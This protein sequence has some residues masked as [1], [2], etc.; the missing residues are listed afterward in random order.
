MRFDIDG[1]ILDTGDLGLDTANDEVA[2]RAFYVQ[3]RGEV[4]SLLEFLGDLFKLREE[5]D[6]RKLWFRGHSRKDYELVPSIGRKTEYAGKKICFSLIQESNLL[7]RFRRRTYL[8]AGRL[9]KAGEALFIARHHGLPTRLL[10]WTAN[11]LF[12]LYFACCEGLNDD[13]Q[14]WALERFDDVT[15]LDSLALAECS[16]EKKLFTAL[17]AGSEHQ[18]SVK[19]IE[20]LYNSARIRAQDGAFT[21]HTDPSLPLNE[22][23]GKKF[24]DA[25]LDIK[26]L[27]SWDVAHDHKR[28]IIEKLSGLGITHR[29]VF[30][31]LDGIARSLWE[32]ETLWCGK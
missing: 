16:T 6:N 31:D 27:Y 25:N 18:C 11:A 1:F 5:L 21:V 12:G 7:H 23:A 26:H 22:Y 24:R 19:I 8:E 28:H 3:H 32:T 14:L 4:E 30:P 13:G 20:P 17:G 2:M 10:D 9:L 15:G 29:S